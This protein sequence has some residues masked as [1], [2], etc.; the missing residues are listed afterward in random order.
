MQARKQAAQAQAQ[1][2][3][4]ITAQESL[5]LVKCLLRVVRGQR[6]LACQDQRPLDALIR[7]N[8]VPAQSIYH[9]SYL[10][11]LF[12]ESCFRGV[13][14]GIALHA[15]LDSGGASFAAHARCLAP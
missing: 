11:G 2:Q 3:A 1:K 8:L 15:G 4:E 14:A 9:V 13:S 6:L 5:E 12:P 10:R 7:F